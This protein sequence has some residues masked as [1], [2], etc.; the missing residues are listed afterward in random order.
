MHMSKKNRLKPALLVL[1]SVAFAVSLCLF[2][3]CVNNDPKE[4][5]LTSIAITKQP[6][7]TEY[8]AGESF[9]KTG[10][11][12]EATYDND[13]KETV[14]DYTVAPGG[15]LKLTD[16]FVTVTYKGKTARQDITVSEAPKAVSIAVTKM[17]DK[18]N[19][20]TGDTFDKTGME[21]TA[22][23]DDGSSAAVTDF[24]V[25]V[26][27]FDSAGDV[28]VIIIYDGLTAQF[29]VTVTDPALTALEITKEPDCTLYDI[30]ENFDATG[31]MLIARY[32]NGVT[33]PVSVDD[34][35]I[36]H[37]GEALEESIT[38]IEF[39]FTDGE[40]TKTV[41]QPIRVI[42]LTL[43]GI[44]VSEGTVCTEYGVGDKFDK[45]GMVVLGIYNNDDGITRI[46]T[47]WEVLDA[48]K[49]LTVGDE[50]MTVRH[51]DFEYSLKITVLPKY[52]FEAEALGYEVK[53]GTDAKLRRGFEYGSV[54]SGGTPENVDWNFVSGTGILINMHTV[55]ALT[56]DVTAADAAEVTLIMNFTSHAANAGDKQYISGI[57]STI[58]VNGTEYAPLPDAATVRSENSLRYN[59]YQEVIV[60][61]KLPLIKG[62]N[63]LKFIF[64]ASYNFDYVAIRSDKVITLTAEKESGHGWTDWQVVKAPTA[65]EAGEM[66][67]YCPVCAAKEIVVLPAN[68][69]DGSV[70]TL[71]ST[72][73]ATYAE[74]GYK[75]YTYDGKTF[76]VK[77]AEALGEATEVLYDFEDARLDTSFNEAYGIF[78]S[79]LDTTAN[80]G[81]HGKGAQ[82]FND[83]GGRFIWTVYANTDAT[84]K[85]QVR[86]GRNATRYCNPTF[87]MRLN[88][89]G[90][91]I[92]TDYTKYAGLNG[93]STTSYF[94]WV[95][96]DFAE[97]E[98]KAG[99]NVIYVDALASSFTNVDD[100]KFISVSDIANSADK[101]IDKVEITKAPD[102]TEY[103]TTERFDATGMI[104]T[105]TYKD[106]TSA[107]V[108]DYY[109]DSIGLLSADT[110]VIAI[111]YQGKV[112]NQPVTVTIHTA[113]LLSI[114][115][116]KAPDK[117]EY[118]AGESF[119]A[120]GM[121]VTAI[122]D[123]ESTAT[124]SYEDLKVTVADPLTGATTVVTLEYEGKTAVVDI[125]VLY[126][127][128]LEAEGGDW[129]ETGATVK[130]F[131]ENGTQSGIARVSGWNNAANKVS[132]DVYAEEETTVKIYAAVQATP[133]ATITGAYAFGKLEINGVA[134]TIKSDGG[135]KAEQWALW[136]V[137]EVATV[138]LEKGANTISLWASTN[139]TNFDFIEI[140]SDA[141]VRWADE[142]NGKMWSDWTID[143]V[144]AAA[145]EG[146]MHRV[147]SH[148]DV[149]TVTLPANLEGGA[150]S[151]VR[152]VESTA[153]LAGY[154]EYSYNGYTFKVTTAAVGEAKDNVF[155][156]E[157]AKHSQVL[158]GTV[159]TA[160]NRGEAV[161]LG[162]SSK[163]LSS[164]FKI[165]SGAAATV[166]LYINGGACGSA[167]NYS[168]R[169]MITIN[170]KPFAIRT[171]AILAPRASSA[172]NANYFDWHYT[173]IGEFEV[174]EGINEIVITNYG[175]TLTNL[176]NIKL[177]SAADIA[178]ETT[179]IALKTAPDKTEYSVGEMFDSNGMVVEARY[180]VN[181]KVFGYVNEIA[182]SF[183]AEGWTVDDGDTPFELGT[184]FVTV[185]YGTFTLEVPVIVKTD[186]IVSIVIKNKPEILHYMPEQQ[187]SA[188]GMDIYG[189]G[190]DSS[191]FELSAEQYEVTLSEWVEGAV[192]VTVTYKDKT[193]LTA[194][195]TIV[196]ASNT[197]R[198][199]A[200][201]AEFAEVYSDF[202]VAS[203]N[204][205]QSGFARI[206]NWN[207]VK[208]KIVFGVYSDEAVNADIYAAAQAT[209]AANL[210]ASYFISKLEVNGKIYTVNSQNG[211]TA[212]AWTTWHELFVATV[213]LRKGENTIAIYGMSNKA[214]FD[215]LDLRSAT[216][217]RWTDE[218]DGKMWGEWILSAAPE[219]ETDGKLYRVSSHGDV[220]TL[221]LPADLESG[222]YTL[223]ETVEA[224]AYVAGYKVY[225]V[226]LDDKTYSFK[227]ENGSASGEVADHIFS[228]R[229]ADGE[230]TVS[231]YKN[232]TNPP[233][234]D[235]TGDNLGLA[236][237]K[238]GTLSYNL[239]V[240]ADATVDLSFN[241]APT[242]GANCYIS[243]SVFIFI[244]GELYLYSDNVYTNSNTP[245]YFT[246]SDYAVTSFDLTG[247]EHTVTFMFGGCNV[248]VLKSVNFKSVADISLTSS[249]PYVPEATFAETAVA[250]EKRLYAA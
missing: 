153:Y 242:K 24:A 193:D 123:D 136:H 132:F 55:N 207:N 201:G 95:Y 115:V 47:E 19:Y 142:T 178:W 91:Y 163:N 186:D 27:K 3:G 209:P 54:G 173:F 74:A 30:G 126:K 199:E 171:D 64:T 248:G 18:I 97:F 194:E 208:N 181:D 80:R 36:S 107:P 39:S 23:Y 87:N 56:L 120:T 238:F 174:S 2:G 88:V 159:Y 29:A 57:L 8:V 65:T 210:T 5:E 96:V 215:Y 58:E 66:G 104:V 188:Q 114:E 125:T 195:F 51:G 176:D 50:A 192:T 146:S 220:E 235:G 25:N 169:L 167:I 78:D 76:K 100:V 46:I 117:T 145:A 144:P 127:S 135:V 94:D 86:L 128:R 90:K 21:V 233:K 190:S 197:V 219:K 247:G 138:K 231:G 143:V 1:L 141:V 139:N 189:I 109:V 12:V 202:Q 49:T 237:S 241:L 124:V 16:T 82:K 226:T 92:L 44:I 22:T 81:S 152:T 161:S 37:A 20:F 227:A 249:E 148:G 60:L 11:V 6:D 228:A 113:T 13:E 166:K 34:C 131:N 218:T 185:R 217:V 102:K 7:K 59:D 245:N 98:V 38:E 106:G 196:V 62:A 160:E 149:E 121:I 204:G 221:I 70:Y 151:V 10:M 4:P 129:S 177:V 31:I 99:E 116:T 130:M 244:D 77:T 119:D 69:A 75:T 61:K 84:V 157:Y 85:M 179:E 234:A 134:A 182:Y 211:V 93:M 250:D 133:A 68:L 213:A 111:Y 48:D 224:T 205:N 180:V 105:A 155:E 236:V 243:G 203:E 103:F 172:V 52:I 140:V 118:V 63:T 184:T 239:T 222:A 42:R 162:A 112:V 158:G 198:L 175:G 212:G 26:K 33:K 35:L 240:S 223:V 67:R 168:Q 164:V 101:M 150:Y 214:N 28:K 156:Y 15:A 216:D 73:E 79:G 9:D 137:I 72:E 225:S 183:V 110:E 32:A 206:A 229:I 40:V 191:E 43:T 45:S 108:T 122:Y 230:G 187:F 14:T 246:Y 89:N 165:R 83:G 53:E 170:G 71:V 232:A 41:A 17:P 200:E 154:T 147:S